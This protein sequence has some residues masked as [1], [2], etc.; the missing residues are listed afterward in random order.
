MESEDD[1]INVSTK[2]TLEKTENTYQESYLGLSRL[3]LAS[4]SVTFTRRKGHYVLAKQSKLKNSLL[5]GVAFLELG[6]AG[7]FA[8]NVWNDI[9]VPH[10]VVALMV[11]GGTLALFL[12]YFAF[13]DAKLGWR[14]L[15][16]LREERRDLQRQKTHDLEDGQII[17]GLDARLNVSFREIGTE[18]ISRV[19]LDVCMGVGGII[20][21][22]GTF[23]AIGGANN[24]VWHASNLMSG[25]IGNVPL[26]LYA[27]F[28]GAW[29]CY[30][31]IKARQH[32]IAGATALN[33]DKA[34]ALLKRRIF[35][36][37]MYTAIVGVT[38]IIAG[39]A[40]L[41]SATMWW[42]YVIL[43]PVIIS[44]ISCNYIWRK[45]IAYERPLVQRALGLSKVS[46]LRELESIVAVQRILKEA[47]FEPLYKL[48]SDSQSITSVIEFIVMNDLFEDFC[49]RLLDDTHLSEL[50]GIPNEEITITSELLLTADNSYVPHILKIAQTCVSEIGPIHFQ[51]RQRYILELLG[52]YLCVSQAGT[53]ETTLEKC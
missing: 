35:T 49:V 40:S 22:I 33:M 9:P 5:V 48:V 3:A 50:F 4:D 10:F 37:Q 52:S 23:L 44:S 15:V 2:S 43:I 38:G 47:P 16:H 32:G 42:G 34:A 11:V 53:S 8:A 21:G 14:N 25:Y 51:Y 18:S 28:N 27:L 24:R 39:A 36:V 7:D 19:G 31:W 41:I 45:K 1:S 20:I 12:S 29:S 46:L 17:Q 26:A 13:K 6:N 30:V